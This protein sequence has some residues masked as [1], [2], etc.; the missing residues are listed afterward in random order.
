MFF[1]NNLN[2]QLLLVKERV[3]GDR[4]P[5]S[6]LISDNESFLCICRIVPFNILIYFQIQ[7]VPY[8][9][10]LQSLSMYGSI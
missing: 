1:I 5:P 4:V 2:S 3:V 10:N 6:G 8:Y 9:V 7:N